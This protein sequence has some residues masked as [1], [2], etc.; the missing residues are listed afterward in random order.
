MSILLAQRLKFFLS[1]NLTINFKTLKNQHKPEDDKRALKLKN[2]SLEAR[3]DKNRKA[4]LKTLLSSIFTQ[5]L[6]S[7]FFF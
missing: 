4:R 2:Q 6:P 5:P 1:F 3:E 7:F